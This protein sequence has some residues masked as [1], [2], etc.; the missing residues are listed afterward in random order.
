MFKNNAEK[1]KI[2]WTPYS[3]DNE[4]KILLLSVFMKGKHSDISFNYQL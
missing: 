3:I 2:I 1:F 4:N